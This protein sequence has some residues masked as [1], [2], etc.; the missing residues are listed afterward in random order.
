[1]RNSI[2]GIQQYLADMVMNGKRKTIV[3][4]PLGEKKQRLFTLM[5]LALQNNNMNRYKSL[6]AWNKLKLK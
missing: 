2:K 6:M 4:K 1:M 5:C 3:T